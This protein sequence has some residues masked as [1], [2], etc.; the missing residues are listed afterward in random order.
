MVVCRKNYRPISSSVR[1]GLIAPETIQ[2]LSNGELIKNRKDLTK[3]KVRINA[4]LMNFL[5]F[6]FKILLSTRHCKFQ[7]IIHSVSVQD[8][9][10]LVCSNEQE[11]F[12][13]NADRAMAGV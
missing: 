11:G 4:Q 6:K 12:G 3:S 13:Y 9:V 5:F 8:G 2:K 1:P 10:I 7:S